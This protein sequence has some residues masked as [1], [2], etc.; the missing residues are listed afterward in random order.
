LAETASLEGIEEACEELAW[1][2]ASQS[3][4]KRLPTSTRAKSTFLVIAIP[5]LS[6][7]RIITK[8]RAE[9]VL[10][11]QTRLCTIKGWMGVLAKDFV[12]SSN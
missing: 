3:K 8:G 1:L 12:N 4:E 2:L 5:P 10:R 7:R 9:V 11:I 6:Y